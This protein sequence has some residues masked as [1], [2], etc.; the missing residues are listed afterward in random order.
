MLRFKHLRLDQSKIEQ[1]KRILGAGTETE[2]IDKALNRV[3]HEDQEKL[4]RKKLLKKIVELRGKIGG[5]DDDAAGWVRMA[6]E[7]RES[8]DDSGY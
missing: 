1:A 2:A 4:R 3:I 7:E 8:S 6:R 5:F